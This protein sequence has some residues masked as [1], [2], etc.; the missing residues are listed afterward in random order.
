MHLNWS[1]LTSMCYRYIVHYGYM[2]S[3]FAERQGSRASAFGD[4]R[5]CVRSDRR[6]NRSLRLLP[7]LVAHTRADVASPVTRVARIAL[8]FSRVIRP[9]T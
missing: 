1:T 8:L 5:E 3:H 9:V 6:G 2:C 7:L 4:I